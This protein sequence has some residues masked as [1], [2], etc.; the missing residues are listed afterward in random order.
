MAIMNLNLGKE[1]TAE[2]LNDYLLEVALHSDF[3]TK[4][5][6]QAQLK[7]YQLT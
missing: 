7:S 3:V 4:L 2:E 6:S 1:T 5:I